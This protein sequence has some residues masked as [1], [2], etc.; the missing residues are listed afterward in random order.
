MKV[1]VYYSTPCES[2]VRLKRVGK[3]YKLTLATVVSAVVAV[4]FAGEEWV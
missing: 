2:V 4:A 3:I 1:D